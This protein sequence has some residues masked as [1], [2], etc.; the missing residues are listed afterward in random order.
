MGA[1]H[2]SIT[3]VGFFIADVCTCDPVY[4]IAIISKCVCACVTL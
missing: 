1:N 3:T 2:M 4:K